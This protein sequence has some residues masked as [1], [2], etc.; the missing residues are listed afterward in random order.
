MC[1]AHD[2]YDKSLETP[3]DDTNINHDNHDDY[4]DLPKLDKTHHVLEQHL[5]LSFCYDQIPDF[6]SNVVP[7]S[8]KF[9]DMK[10]FKDVKKMENILCKKPKSPSGD[11]E[12]M[13]Q[14]VE[15]HLFLTIG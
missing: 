14:M 11:S 5:T 7:G 9:K 15:E 6:G 12:I 2:S 4:D 3:F 1:S 10:R 13:G 8:R